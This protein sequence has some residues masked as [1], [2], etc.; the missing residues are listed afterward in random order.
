[1]KLR[2]T[3]FR[4]ALLAALLATG[5]LTAQAQSVGVGTTAP[6]ASAALDIVST[7]KGALLPRVTGTGSVTNPAT[8]LIVFQTG[9]PAGYYYYTG[10]VGGWQQIAT[11]SGAAITASNGLTKVGAEIQLG[12]TLTKATTIAN[13]GNALNVTGTGTTSF[14]GNVGIGTTAPATTLDVTGSF[15]VNTNSVSSQLISQPTFNNTFTGG[16][17]T[18]GQSFT[19][20]VAGTLTSVALNFYQTTTTS[21]TF[22][23]GGGNTGAVLGTSQA[24]TFAAN[25]LQTVTLATPIA[26]PA[27]VY[28][29]AAG[30]NA[31][32]VSSANPY[33]G[34]QVYINSSANSSFAGYDLAFAVGY[35]T[36]STS[37]TLYAN[38]GNVGIGI[39]A[40][41]AVLDVNGSTRLRGLPTAGV[42]TTDASG[43]L[44]SGTAAS[45]DATTASNGLTKVGT[46]I[47][48]GG[49]LTGATTIGLG[50][51][52]LSF[53]STGGNVGIGTTAPLSR[54]SFGA[55]TNANAAAGRLAIY[56]NTTG[57]NFYGLGLVQNGASNYGMGLWGGTNGLQPY[58]GAAGT[59]LPHLY[60]DQLTANVGIGTITPNAQLQ[61]GNTAANRKIV[62]Y[63]AANNDHQFSGFGLNTSTLRYQVPTATDNHVFFRGVDATTSVELMRIQ[64]DGKV[65]IGTSAPA[66][67]LD[68]NGNLR[69]AVRLAPASTATYT[70]TAADIAFSIFKTQIG[71]AVANLMLPA[72]GTGQVEGQELTIINASDINCTVGGSTDNG[73]G[74][75]LPTANGPGVHAVKYVWATYSG[76][77]GSWFRVQ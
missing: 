60:L 45:L 18:V 43:N 28:T 30:I 39:T 41:T 46:D 25:T 20:P 10:S 26:L 71:N 49:N 47:Q 22:Y 70:L 15:N 58:N 9:A 11:A 31:N 6:D 12:G 38:S 5:G 33:A 52:N 37:S 56:E 74:V 21:V 8:G 59:Q 69:L 32:N 64:G 7:T 40:P 65:G 48:L 53:T 2:I 73:G 19:L 77:T 24:V 3:L 67:K 62:L 27:G 36:S 68:V 51:N 42:V 17:V 34:G 44:S 4:H 63:E 57:A 61:L 14:G 1:M 75:T 16:G 76:G 23:Q 54:L 35:T 13:A 72:G 50:A 29:L 66:T 55:T